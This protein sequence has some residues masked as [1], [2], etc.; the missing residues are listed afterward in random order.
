MLRGHGFRPRPWLRPGVGIGRLRSFTRNP[1][2]GDRRDRNVCRS[3][4]GW[5]DWRDIDDIM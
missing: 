3:A 4:C 1:R 5:R 2:H